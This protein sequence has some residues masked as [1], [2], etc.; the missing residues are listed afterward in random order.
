MT[1]NKLKVIVV[2]IGGVGSGFVADDPISILE[3]YRVGLPI[4]IIS[5]PVIPSLQNNCT[6]LG[7]ESQATQTLV[8][9]RIPDLN[10]AN[11]SLWLADLKA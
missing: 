10:L 2:C 5:N 9:W 6:V 7:V 1:D 11:L 8:I 3:I 4:I